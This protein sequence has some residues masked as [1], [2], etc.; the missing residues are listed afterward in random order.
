[1][2]DTTQ[3]A[4]GLRF[5]ESAMP[6]PRI[7]VTLSRRGTKKF[8]RLGKPHASADFVGCMEND[9]ARRRRL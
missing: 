4:W 8:G 5:G 9:C 7:S 2:N 6:V 3:R 1:M